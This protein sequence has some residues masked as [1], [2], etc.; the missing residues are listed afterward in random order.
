MTESQI[1]TLFRELQM[2]DF[3]RKISLFYLEP[4]FTTDLVAK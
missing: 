1:K 2:Y 3:I 4:S